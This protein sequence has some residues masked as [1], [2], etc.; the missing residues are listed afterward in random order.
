V[1]TLP[2][3]LIALIP[4]AVLAHWLKIYPHRPLVWVLLVPAALS[5]ALAVWEDA[6]PL[7]L[8]IDAAVAAAA[9]GDLVTLPR[10]G[11]FLAERNCGHIASLGK[12]HRVTLTVSNRSRMSRV[13]WIRDGADE[14]LRPD[15]EDFTLV[16]PGMS[17]STVH[18]DL[19]P[20]RRGRFELSELFLRARS[21]L[22][23][24][25]RHLSY[26]CES[27]I[28]V[29]PDMKQLGEYAVL[30]RTDRLSLLGVRRTRKIGQ[31]NE[32][33]RLRDYTLDDNY[34]HIDWRSTARRNK[35]TVRDFQANQ[36][37]RIIFLIDCGR[38]A[39]TCWI[40]PATRC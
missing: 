13:V 36:S 16:L 24:W 33:E 34:K 7:V 20:R 6:L 21:R 35:L 40:T 25:Q 8:A 30:A 38:G 37:Q 22:G 10:H 29:Y 12:P 32:F 19:R 14:D 1:N 27:V 23:F 31:D 17:R 4:L 9:I 28:A 2:L 26:A 18:Y 15:P 39:S 3:L 5:I 11:T